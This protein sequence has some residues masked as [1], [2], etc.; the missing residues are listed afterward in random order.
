MKCRYRKIDLIEWL[1]KRNQSLNHST[2]MDQH[3]KADPSCAKELAELEPTLNLMN[4]DVQIDEN[5]SQDDK[6]VF[7]LQQKINT[8]QSLSLA[9]LILKPAGLWKVMVSGIVLV[10][11]VSLWNTHTGGK[12]NI[13]VQSNNMSEIKIQTPHV[14]LSNI[15]PTHR[16]G[17]VTKPN[18]SVSKPKFPEKP[19]IRIGFNRYR[20]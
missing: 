9:A 20:I 15:K 1:L 12:K 18:I 10:V 8:R 16:L 6:F 13:S 19:V 3:I 4:L 2:E 7:D 17:G 11:L 14:K 5:I